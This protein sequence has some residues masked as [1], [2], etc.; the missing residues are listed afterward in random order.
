MLDPAIEDFFRE[1]KELWHKKKI[2]STM[3]EKEINKKKEECEKEFLL[4]NWLPKAAK[5]AKQITL[6]THPCTFSHPSARK[7]KNGDVTSVFV[8]AQREA[9]GYLRSGNVI[10]EN[11]ILLGNAVNFPVYRFLM[12]K[13]S[14]SKELLK[15]IQ[16]NSALAVELLTIK[17]ESYQKLK[18]GFLAMINSDKNN[19]DITSSKIKQVYFPVLDTYHQ[20]STL[21]NSGIIFELKETLRYYANDYTYYGMCGGHGYAGA[22]IQDDYGKNAK[23]ILAKHNKTWTELYDQI[24]RKTNNIK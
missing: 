7:N 18:D 5:Q 19:V 12:L 16:E 6:S 24:D 1:R 2:K 20:L 14:D 11:D 9:D 21:S 8:N 15:H 13:M 23:I 3:N 22:K 4:E 17:T 10:V